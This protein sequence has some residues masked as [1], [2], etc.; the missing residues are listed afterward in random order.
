MHLRRIPS[1]SI[2]LHDATLSAKHWAHT[3]RT[4][5]SSKQKRS[6]SAGGLGGVPLAGV[7]GS[8]HPAAAR[9]G[10]PR[11]LGDLTCAHGSSTREHEVADD[12]PRRARRSASSRGVGVR[13]TR[14]VVL[15]LVGGVG[16]ATRRPR[17]AVGTATWP[18]RSASVARRM[19]AGLCAAASPARPGTVMRHPAG[20]S[21]RGDPHYASGVASAAPARARPAA[22]A[23]T[24]RAAR[25]TRRRR[26]VAPRWAST[27]RAATITSTAAG[28]RRASVEPGAVGET[29]TWRALSGWSVAD[30]QPEPDQAV[31]DPAHGRCRHVLG[32]RAARPACTV[33][34]TPAPTARTA[35]PGSGRTSGP[36]R[37]SRAAGGSQP[38]SGRARSPAAERLRRA[39]SCI[40]SLT[41]RDANQSGSMACGWSR[42][43]RRPTTSPARP[44]FYADLLGRGRHGDVRPAGPGV[45]R[46]RTG[47]GCCWTAVAPSGAALLRCRRH[48]R[49]RR[50]DCAPPA[51]S[52]RREPHV[53]FG[54]EDD[55]LGPAGT[56]EWMAF[57]ARLRGK[58]R[59]TRRAASARLSAA[60]GHNAMHEAAGRRPP[61]REPRRRRAHAGRVRRRRST[62][63][64]EAFECDV[65]LTADGHL[66][67]VHDRDL[68]RTASTRGIVSTHGPR[69]PRLSS[70]SPPG[71]TRGPTSTTRRPT[72]TSRSARC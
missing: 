42:S 5:R 72:A 9:T 43:H 22:P 46:P 20:R 7:L 17:V 8:D 12:W 23:R 33:P 57:V 26:R 61:R 44:A 52:S 29:R 21:A 25:R 4:P 67:C 48:R 49:D 47:S 37:A 10:C 24:G 1:C 45:L 3:R 56:D 38:S 71:R 32:A 68:R 19:A 2:S 70:T 30:H 14:A 60:A 27:R 6:S 51:S 54:H 64:A 39:S 62:H 18:P 50:A 58:H 40:A 35:G 53:I 28:R 69:R 36:R 66:V 11:L 55:T 34:R 59:G 15:R 63:G 65:R 13:G 41:V 16:S 31:D